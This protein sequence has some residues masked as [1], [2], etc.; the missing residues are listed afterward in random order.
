MKEK[1]ISPIPDP[2][3]KLHKNTEFS[4]CKML[5]IPRNPKEKPSLKSFGASLRLTPKRSMSL[6]RFCVLSCLPLRV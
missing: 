5:L 4:E 6:R 2:E 1:I 3:I